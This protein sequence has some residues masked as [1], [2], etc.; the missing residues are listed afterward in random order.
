MQLLPAARDWLKYRRCILFSE[1]LRAVLWGKA[2]SYYCMESS[3]CCKL[4]ENGLL[5]KL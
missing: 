1:D 3:L 2:Q 5:G 4:I